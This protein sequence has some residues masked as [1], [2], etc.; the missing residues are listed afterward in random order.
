MVIAVQ[1]D[2]TTDPPFVSSAGHGAWVK[3]GERTFAMTFLQIGY[4]LDGTLVGIFKVRETITLDE[5]GMEYSGQSA[6]EASDPDGNPVFSGSSTTQAR[7]ILV[8][9]L[10]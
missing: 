6:L 4:G 1:A 7:R 3:T 5:S 9:P 8:E 10:P 2:V